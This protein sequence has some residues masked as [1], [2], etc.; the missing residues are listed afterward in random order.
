MKVLV[1]DG[2]P[3]GKEGRTMKLTEKFIEGVKEARPDCLVEYICLK[4]VRIEPCTGCS[5]CWR[6]TRGRCVID[7]DAMSIRDKYV[8]ADII[9]WS[10][11]L[12][13][14]GAPSKTKACMDRIVFPSLMPQ[15]Y[16]DKDGVV[17]HPWRF[18]GRHEKQVLISTCGF[19][20]IEHNFDAL[21]AQMNIIN[22]NITN[23]LCCASGALYPPMFDAYRERVEAYLADVK[24]AGIEY[25]RN[26]AISLP[27]IN[28][29]KEPLVP[30]AEFMERFNALWN[31]D[32]VDER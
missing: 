29:L 9:V 25:I 11:P 7:D 30:P 3:K 31:W 22:A 4:D 5:A 18:K 26:D 19:P 21:L 20:Q 23:I 27:V 14:Y 24:Q 15:M 17:R 16:Y 32:Y 6:K 8:K 1:L 13:I 10:F 28:R 2:S 12:Y